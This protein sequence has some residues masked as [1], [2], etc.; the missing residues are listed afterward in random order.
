MKVKEFQLG[1][2]GK[3]LGWRQACDLVV[4][5]INFLKVREALQV[6]QISFL[7]EVSLEIGNG[8]IFTLG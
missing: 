4:T 6:H 1:E 7:Y 2:T 8:E 5:Q 3:Y